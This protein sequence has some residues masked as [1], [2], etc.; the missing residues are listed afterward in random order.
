M[1]NIEEMITYFKDKDNKSKEKYQK[2]KTLFT[3]LK[4]F[5]TIVNIATTT[6]FITSL[7]GFRLKFLTISSSIACG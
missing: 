4:S 1:N 3:I 2:K 5:D 7:S 6:C